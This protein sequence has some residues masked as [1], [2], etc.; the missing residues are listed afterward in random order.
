LTR[1]L[2]GTET[3]WDSFSVPRGEWRSLRNHGDGDALLL[4]MTAGD[5]RKRITWDEGVQRRAA[6]AGWVHDAGGFV[7]PRSYVERA[8]K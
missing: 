2:V 7:A 8:Q 3:G 5:A 4:V 1:T 6:A